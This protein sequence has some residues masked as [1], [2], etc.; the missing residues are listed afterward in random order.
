MRVVNIDT[1]THTHTRTHACTHAHTYTHTHTH[2]HAHTHT[3][4]ER[5]CLLVY[6][7]IP[8]EDLIISNNYYKSKSQVYIV[9]IIV[10]MFTIEYV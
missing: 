7:Y 10:S 5:S 2:T 1:H 9:S 6:S 8:D 3:Y 4:N